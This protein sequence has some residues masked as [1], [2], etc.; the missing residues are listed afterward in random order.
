MINEIG[1]GILCVEE[2]GTGNVWQLTLVAGVSSEIESWKS[3][4]IESLEIKREERTSRIA[5]DVSTTSSC[6]HVKGIGRVQQTGNLLIHC[7]YS[8]A[9]TPCEGFGNDVLRVNTQLNSSRAHIA[10]VG[11]LIVLTTYTRGA[12]K[13]YKVESVTLIH[14]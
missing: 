13:V 9:G 8:K 10:E 5:H 14:I 7:T 6:H 4:V 1:L 3:L 11:I 2:V 12:D